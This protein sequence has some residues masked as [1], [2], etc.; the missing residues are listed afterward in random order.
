[1][2]QIAAPIGINARAEERRRKHLDRADALLGHAEEI[3]GKKTM[4]AA[5]RLQAS[6][7]IWGSVAHT[8]K[9]IA[10]GNGWEIHK[11]SGLDS[12]RQHL[13]K[14]S[15][16][17]SIT[18]GYLAAY[19]VHVNFYQDYRSPE[20]LRSGAVIARN[21]NRKLLAAAPSI[22]AGARPPKN[23]HRLRDR[24]RRAT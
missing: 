4:T 24:F 8:L 7:K 5:D 10:A 6:E 14:E 22:R 3:V 16:D 18:E 19:A 12:L 20:D 11:T 9:A 21:L 13:A 2:T 1:M 23:V 17:E 15:G